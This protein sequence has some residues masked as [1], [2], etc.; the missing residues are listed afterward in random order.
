VA[1]SWGQLVVGGENLRLHRIAAELASGSILAGPAL[2]AVA[3]HAVS[4]LNLALTEVTDAGES[5]AIGVLLSSAPN[6]RSR[7]SPPSAGPPRS[8]RSS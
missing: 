2:D 6:E 7:T 1:F 3:A 8:R 4:V 5:H